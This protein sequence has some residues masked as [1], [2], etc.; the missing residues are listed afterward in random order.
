MPLAPKASDLGVSWMR[1]I[2]VQNGRKGQI[3]F[4]QDAGP[5]DRGAVRLG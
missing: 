3:L 2:D 1:L 5:D 4:L